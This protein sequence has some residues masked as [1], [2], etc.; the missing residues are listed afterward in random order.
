MTH[1]I[2]QLESLLLE[3]IGNNIFIKVN[4]YIAHK[5]EII[6]TIQEAYNTIS[7]I[8]PLDEQTEAYITIQAQL[9]ELMLLNQL[10]NCFPH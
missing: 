2:R 3:R 10:W 6:D 1:S 5:K 8:Y 7:H 4:E 9:K